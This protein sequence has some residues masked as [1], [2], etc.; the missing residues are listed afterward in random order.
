MTIG[1]N[2]PVETAAVGD[3]LVR[4]IPLTFPV[5]ANYCVEAEIVD[6]STEEI[7]VLEE[8]VDFNLTD[9]D[10]LNKTCIFSLRDNGVYPGGWSP[11]YPDPIAS[12]QDWLTDGT[13]INDGRLKTGWKLYIYFTSNAAQP[14][15]LSNA[16]PRITPML[17]EK[18]VD[19]LTM[20]VRALRR[21][22][23][24][25]VGYNPL[26][27]EQGE[28]QTG[29]WILEELKRIERLA[30]GGGT[31]VAFQGFSSRFNELWDSDGVE[32]TLAKIIKITYQAPAIALAAAP[33][34]SL[35][36]KGDVVASVNLTAAL[37]RM[38]ED[39]TTLTFFRNGGSP[40]N[41][42]PAPTGGSYP[43]TYAVPF[44]DNT[45]FSATVGDGT[46]TNT[47][48]VS[49]NF[50]YPYYYGV[51]AAGLTGTQIAALLT[52]D[53]RSSSASV[54]FQSSPSVQH[55]YFC[56]PAAY[57]ALTSILDQNGFETLPAYTARTVSITGLD[58]TAQTYRV[59]ELTIPTTQVNFT[60]TYSR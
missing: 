8:G 54:S 14:T 46:G 34:A 43:T 18:M 58:G 50:V 5:Y 45:T 9:V 41:V 56:Y 1:I 30:L 16:I 47:A 59:Y 42:T 39:I 2:Q 44:S 19:R 51:G 55:F 24:H 17:M 27:L 15:T 36:E 57:P 60:N 29:E 4:L 40:V 38:S 13:V 37:T 35:R 12:R 10:T 21:D 28:D 48:T 32:D 6:L 22:L 3:D 11:G 26:T 20:H 7:F 49:F 52:K 23:S 33:S 53:I 25:K 31:D